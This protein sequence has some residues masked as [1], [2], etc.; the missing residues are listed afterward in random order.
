MVSPQTIKMADGQQTEYEVIA[1]DGTQGSVSAADRAKVSGGYK[2]TGRVRMFA[3]DGTEGFV[4]PQHMAEAGRQGYTVTPKT[5]FEQ[6]RSGGGYLSGVESSLPQSSVLNTTL[7]ALPGVAPAL[8]AIQTV[9]N[10]PENYQ[11]GAASAQDVTPKTGI[12]LIDRFNQAV[13]GATG[14]VAGAVA[15]F[16]GVNPISQRAR[17]DRGDTAGILGENTLPVASAVLPMAAKETIGAVAPAAA[18]ALDAWA[19]K[20]YQQVL[21]PTKVTT[22]FQTQKLVPQLLEERPKAFTRQGLADKAAAQA[23]A[24]GQQIEDAVSNLSGSMETQP[25]IDGLENLRQK[26][27]VNGVSLRPEVDG[28]INTLQDQLRAMSQPGDLPDGTQGPGEA[29]IS[30]QDVVKA[31]RILDDAVAEV[32]GYQGRPLSDTSMANIRKAT[33]NSIREELSKASPD[34][35]AV[36]AKFHFWDTLSDVLEQTIQ[37]KTGQVNAFP[38][39][40]SAV[41][42]AGGLA[43][44][45]LSTGLAYGAAMK[46]LGATIRSTGWNTL[47]AATKA[48]I[49]DALASGQFAQVNK[50]LGQT[51]LAGA[52]LGSEQQSE[53]PEQQPDSSAPEKTGAALLEKHGALGM[54][55]FL[56]NPV[57]QDVLNTVAPNMT[58]FLLKRVGVSDKTTFRNR[59]RNA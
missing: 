42:A 7:S 46:V 38:K 1:P 53:Q 35:A 51:G 6:Q 39:L 28:A 22:K 21:N 32:G 11:A 34:L 31:R 30:Y 50:L 4:D 12:P 15:P 2:L 16:V 41:A 3:P 43:K 55:Q 49:A 56:N 33:A 57:A 13:S 44:G 45:G 5:Q 8:G 58:A 24:A 47:S 23:D 29:T 54:R 19:A 52:A 25:V 26:Y 27:Q 14:G 9:K 59:G 37:R 17:A 36:N 48:S 20:N 40:E 10:A 18:D